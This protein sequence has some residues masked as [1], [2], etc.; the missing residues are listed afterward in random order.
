MKL[1]KILA[2]S[3]FLIGYAYQAPQ[4]AIASCDKKQEECLDKCDN[5]NPDD[6]NKLQDCDTLCQKRFDICLKASKHKSPVVVKERPVIVESP[7]PPVVYEE[8]PPVVVEPIPPLYGPWWGHRWH[9]HH[10]F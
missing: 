8:Y 10:R 3:G 2:L 5:N 6:E 1:T 4:P 9:H 7:P